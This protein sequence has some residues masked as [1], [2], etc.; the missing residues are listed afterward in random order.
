MAVGPADWSR[1]T[2][3]PFNQVLWTA[4]GIVGQPDLMPVIVIGAVIGFLVSKALTPLLPKRKAKSGGG[5][6]EPQT[7]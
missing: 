2:H 5:S 6:K 7:T 3:R 1:R 4:W